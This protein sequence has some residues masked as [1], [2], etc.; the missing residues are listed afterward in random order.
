MN[1]SDQMTFVLLLISTGLPVKRILRLFGSDEHLAR[2]LMT[3]L[4][5]CGFLTKS[6][7]DAAVT[8]KGQ[9]RLES[10]KLLQ[11]LYQE[12]V[13]PPTSRQVVGSNSQ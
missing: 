1:P 12:L 4:V 2:I 10:S 13:G 6:G 11:N 9:S 3:S 5:A 7:D 8:A